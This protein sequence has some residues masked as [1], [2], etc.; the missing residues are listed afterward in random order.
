MLSCKACHAPTGDDMRYCGTCGEPLADDVPTRR[1]PR[2]SQLYPAGQVIGSYKLLEVLGEGGMGRVYLAEHTKLGRKVALKMLRSKFSSN[3]ETVKRFFAEARAVNRIAHENIVEVTDFVTLDDGI[4][5]YIMELLSGQTL[6]DLLE[7]DGGVDHQQVLDILLQ[8]AS[9]L[10]AVH[11]AGIVHRDL[12]PDNIFLARR[13]QRTVVKL[14]D[15]GI[16]KLIEPDE[17]MSIQS[18]GAGMILGTPTYMSPEQAGGRS[19]D[20]TSDIY[21]LGVIMYEMATGAAPFTADTYAE[22]LVQHLTQAPARPSTVE[23]LRRPVLPELEDLLLRCLKKEPGQRPASMLEVEEELRQIQARLAR[24]EISP[25]AASAAEPAPEGAAAG[26]PDGAPARRGRRLLVP[27]LLGLLVL[28]A[29]AAAL[30]ALGVGRGGDR[31]TPAA[32]EAAGTAPEAAPTATEPEAPADPAPTIASEPPAAG[33]P[34][35]AENEAAAVEP[36]PAAEPAKPPPAR[37]GRKR[38]SK[39]AASQKKGAAKDSK[40]GGKTDR[41]LQKSGVLDVFGDD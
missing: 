33:E 26:E 30:F 17:G 38:S 5:F 12:K 13:G 15:F 32:L 20:P 36:P 34:E 9:A 29:G 1:V 31:P 22:I 27:V 6:S 4:S 19:V 40:S 8:V 35:L 11:Q 28:G 3:P 39:A 7:Q 24:E 41:R 25:R 2:E 18:T 21:S 14:L 10:A 37:T 23:G 16:A